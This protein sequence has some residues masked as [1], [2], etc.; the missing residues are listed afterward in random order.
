MDNSDDCGIVA[1]EEHSFDFNPPDAAVESS[2]A[3]ATGFD[4][5]FAETIDS[6]ENSLASAPLLA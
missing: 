1:G 5:D 4:A 6:E 3:V 2:N